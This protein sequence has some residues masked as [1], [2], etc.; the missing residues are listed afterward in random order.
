MLHIILSPEDSLGEPDISVLPHQKVFMIHSCGKLQDE[1]WILICAQ[2]WES[3]K[4]T[5]MRFEFLK[6]ISA[7]L[8]WV[9]N[10]Y[11]ITFHLPN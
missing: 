8:H 10:R 6:S 9:K 4:C 11:T 5:L 1:G 7:E 3:S 2:L